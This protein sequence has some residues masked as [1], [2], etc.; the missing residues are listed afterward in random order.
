MVRRD[1]N[2]L[3]ALVEL[4]KWHEHRRRDFARALALTERAGAGRLSP[5]ERADLVRRRER[6]ERKLAMRQ[7][8]ADT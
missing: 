8:D 6:L 4:A 5:E 3:F 1:G 2:D 7:V